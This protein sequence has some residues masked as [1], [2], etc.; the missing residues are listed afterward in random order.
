[1]TILPKKIY[2]FN[3]INPTRFFVNIIKCILKFMWKN[4]GLRIAK[5]ILRKKTKV[6][7][8]TLLQVKSYSIAIVIKTVLYYQRNRLI[9]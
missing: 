6:G 5:A 2:G 1:M 7:D 4:T 3:A 9:K 8:V